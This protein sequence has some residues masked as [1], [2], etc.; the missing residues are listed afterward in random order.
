MLASGFMILF[1]IFSRL[2]H[3][4]GGIVWISLIV[5][6]LMLPDYETVVRLLVIFVVSTGALALQSHNRFCVTKC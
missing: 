4:L 5:G 2:G 3:F 6:Q 1:G